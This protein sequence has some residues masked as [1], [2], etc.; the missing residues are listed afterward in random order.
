MPDWSTNF[1]LGYFNISF[2]GIDWEEGTFFF[3]SF[4]TGSGYYYCS[5]SSPPYMPVSTADQFRS[6]V[7]SFIAEFLSQSG[8]LGTNRSLSAPPVVP[9]SAPLIRRA[10]GGLGAVTPTG[11]PPTES[12]GEVLPMYQE[13]VPPPILHVHALHYVRFHSWGWLPCP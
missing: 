2:I 13:D 10:A 9:D 1:M 4:G 3:F 5:S 7:H 8:Q 12:P 11:V 6:Y